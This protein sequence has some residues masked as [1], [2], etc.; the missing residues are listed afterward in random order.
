MSY[1]IELK[2]ALKGYTYDQ[3]KI[4][5]PEKTVAGFKEKTAR[6]NLDIL[7]RTRRIDNGRLDIPVF[8]SECGSDA[9]NVVG[10]KKQMGKGG[11]P[12]QSEASAVME[13]AERF[14]FFS[15]VKK[16]TNFFY[17][18]PKELGEK[19]LSY[20]QII[21]SVHDNK[22]DALKVKPIFD[23]L[24]LK[25]TKGYNLT[26]QK[27][28]L[29]PFNWFY[30]INEFN[31]PSAGN[32]TEEALSQGICE[33]VERHTS[34][35]VSHENLNI[36]GINLDSF[37][38][39]LVIE[40][41][42]KYEK[43][44]IKVYASDFSLDTGIPTIGILAWDPVTFPRMSEIV[45]TAGTSPDPEKA[46]SR[47]L[48]ETAQLAGDFNSGSNYV[49][50]GLPKF[51]SIEDARFITHPEKM[52]NADTLSDLSNN[53]IKTEVENLIQTLDKKGYQIL[54]ISTLH[55]SIEIPAFYTIIPGAHF[56]E[57][58]VAASVGMF[59]ARLITES[60]DPVKALSKL[61]DLEKALPGKY[62]TSF[63]KGLMLNAIYDQKTALTE[64]ETALKR[65]PVKLNMP[66]ICSHM[67][68]CL[69]DLEQY[70]RAVEICKKGL[71]IDEQRPDMFNTMGFC[72]F[73]LKNHET[74]ITCFENAL[75]VDPSLAINYA[76]IGSNYRELGDFKLAIQY[77]E[78][79]LE[80]DPSITFARDNIEKL[81]DK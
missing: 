40:I 15:F 25:W 79:A 66:D 33:L 54:A 74:A 64:F 80:I 41:L 50:S 67:G 76:N 70:D 48:T 65:D 53:N 45:W 42:N 3:D 24:P 60:F 63:Y 72:H 56:R 38:D 75:E 13:L 7:S 11:T 9:K 4:M 10:T 29:I 68:A 47:A 59:S 6:L 23:S 19:A 57:R 44:G 39:P 55:E 35:I 22:E 2:D 81:K 34:S 28:V 58:A 12:A 32:C 46:M 43:E 73:M 31:G 62:Y 14:S 27:E 1:K 18:T 78:M 26:K 61:D 16:E 71:E 49:A 5:S 8:F 77:Y 21:K 51:T 36:P 52:V 30:M 69:K 17:S 37:T 20:D